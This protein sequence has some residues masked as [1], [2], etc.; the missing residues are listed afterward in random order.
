MG[1]V[2][3][4][5]PGRGGTVLVGCFDTALPPTWVDLGPATLDTP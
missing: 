5:S 3:P 2:L 4:M 1:R